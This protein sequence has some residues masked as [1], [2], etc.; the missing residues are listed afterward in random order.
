MEYISKVVYHQFVASRKGSDREQ[1]GT[2][3]PERWEMQ[4]AGVAT[5]KVPEG[6]CEK[7]ED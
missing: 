7:A 1:E 3:I 4:E 2:V 5:S 6:G